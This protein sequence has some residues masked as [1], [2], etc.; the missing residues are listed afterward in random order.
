MIEV[1]DCHDAVRDLG[2]I[3]PARALL[4]LEKGSK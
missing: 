4:V 2:Q 3:M 1:S